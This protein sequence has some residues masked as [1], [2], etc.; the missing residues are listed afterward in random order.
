MGK[1]AWLMHTSLLATQLKHIFV[2][3]DIGIDR[4]KKHKNAENNS[5]GA[6]TYAF[7]CD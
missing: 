4:S 2:T 3:Q 7:K 6:S 5:E 1:L